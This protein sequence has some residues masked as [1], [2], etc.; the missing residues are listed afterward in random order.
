VTHELH[1][2]PLP[3]A[4][5]P[6]SLSLRLRGLAVRDHCYEI[7]AV[8]LA[9]IIERIMRAAPQK[10]QHIGGFVPQPLGLRLVAIVL[11]IPACM[12]LLLRLIG[13]SRTFDGTS[14]DAFRMLDHFPLFIAP[15]NQEREDVLR[16]AGGMRDTAWHGCSGEWRGGSRN[17]G[18]VT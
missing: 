5:T 3:C 16:E 15:S 7:L 4:R 18:R 11:T 8:L 10:L 9:Q 1:C 13:A 2:S 17:S 14:E 6:H 12:V